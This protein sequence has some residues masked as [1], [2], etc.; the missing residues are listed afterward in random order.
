MLSPGEGS[1]FCG[2]LEKAA[3]CAAAARGYRVI[4]R[5]VTG[6]RASAERVAGSMVAIVRLLM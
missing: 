2:V 1:A 6:R 5:A 3:R 4:S